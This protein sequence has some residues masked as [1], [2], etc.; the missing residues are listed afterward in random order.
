LGVFGLVLTTT[1]TG[2]F[3]VDGGSWSEVDGTAS[4]ASAPVVLSVRTAEAQLVG[5]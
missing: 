1:Y 4:V 5:E 2:R 3:R